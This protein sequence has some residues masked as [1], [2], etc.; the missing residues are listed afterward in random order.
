MGYSFAGNWISYYHK[1]V[2]PPFHCQIDIKYSHQLTVIQ[3]RGILDIYVIMTL[4]KKMGGR[5]NLE[6]TG[7]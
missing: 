3:K 6:T 1:E 2:V 5:L 7:A 4:Q